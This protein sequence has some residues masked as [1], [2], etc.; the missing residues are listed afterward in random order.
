MGGDIPYENINSTSRRSILPIFYFPGSDTLL[1]LKKCQWIE[2][3][4]VMSE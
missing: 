1:E 4:K 3:M 2:L